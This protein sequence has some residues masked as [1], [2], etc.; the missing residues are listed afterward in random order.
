[1]KYKIIIF[2]VALFLNSCINQRIIHKSY[3]ENSYGHELVLNLKSDSTFLFLCKGCMSWD[4]ISGM[5]RAN[6]NKIILNSFLKKQDT[7]SYHE[8]VK[9]DTCNEGIYINVM[10]FAE[11]SKLPF[12]IVTAF[13]KGSIVLEET[14]N[15]YGIAIIN[16][17]EIDSII[18]EYIG[19]NP[20]TFV[21]DINVNNLYNVNMKKENL[22]REVID[23][24]VWKIRKNKIISPEG[25]S[26]M[27]KN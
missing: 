6:K 21:P 12:S 19:F 26:L 4:S 3:I 13:D 25:L 23:N 14:T 2:F 27:K 22:N 10:D 11:K 24:E 15:K 18:V 1:M 7:K 9:C 8:C 20:Y 5:W 17:A 16:D